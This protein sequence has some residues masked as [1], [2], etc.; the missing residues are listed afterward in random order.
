[1]YNDVKQMAEQAAKGSATILQ[2]A[3]TEKGTATLI[4]A[5]GASQFKFLEYL[6]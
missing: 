4:L 6:Q 2:K 1:M 3:I 5:T